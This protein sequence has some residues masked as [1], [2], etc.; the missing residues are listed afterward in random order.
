MYQKNED[1][2]RMQKTC[3]FFAYLIS[4]QMSLNCPD[5]ECLGPFLGSIRV[6]QIPRNS[7]KE[8]SDEIFEKFGRRSLSQSVLIDKRVKKCI[9]GY[10]GKKCLGKEAS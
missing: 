10:M 4:G 5:E 7:K 1:G 6:I 9:M 8:T 3:C 2:V